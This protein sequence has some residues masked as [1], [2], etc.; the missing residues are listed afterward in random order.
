LTKSFSE[1]RANLE[2]SVNRLP[3]RTVVVVTTIANVTP[4]R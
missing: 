2:E 3:S 1:S 4:C